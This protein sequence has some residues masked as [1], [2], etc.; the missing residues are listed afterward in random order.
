MKRSTIKNICVYCGAGVG[1]S[2]VYAEAAKSLGR[3]MANEGIGLVYGGASV[4]LMGEIAREVLKEGGRVVGIVPANMPAHE[5]PMQGMTEKINVQSLHER[6]MIMFERAD[7]FVALPGGVGTLEELVE[8]ITW[9]QLGHHH[10]PV[11][12]ANIEDYWRPLLNLFEQ[13]RSL[14][15]ISPSMDV[16]YGVAERIEDI[17]PMLRANSRAASEPLPIA[18]PQP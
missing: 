11:I 1:A 6:K 4:G 9:V 12:I 16:K 14:K 13:M 15:F 10:K 2:P 3:L 18:A 7:A 5:P 8:Q 17:I